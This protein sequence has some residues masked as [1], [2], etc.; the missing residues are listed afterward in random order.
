MLKIEIS[1]KKKS[2]TMYRNWG[3]FLGLPG[4]DYPIG[5][6]LVLSYPRDTLGTIG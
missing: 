4:V 3:R 5:C 1:M 2:L 6:I